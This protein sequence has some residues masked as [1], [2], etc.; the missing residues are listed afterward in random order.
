MAPTQSRAPGRPARTP[1]EERPGANDV[2]PWEC[3][4]LRVRKK[5]FTTKNNTNLL[6]NSSEL[7]H[8]KGME[9]EKCV[10]SDRNCSEPKKALSR[11]ALGFPMC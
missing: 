1:F 2:Q 10:L 8:S 11:V 5:V 7:E 4:I 9:N 6:S 3:S